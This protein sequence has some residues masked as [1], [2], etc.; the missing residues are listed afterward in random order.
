MSGE[1]NAKKGWAAQ[2]SD[3]VLAVGLVGILMA[4]IIPLP[5]VALDVLLTLN[6]SYALLLL[7]IVLGVSSPLDLSTFPSLLL[8]GTLLRLALNV[9]STRLIL[10]NAYAGEVIQSFGHFVVGGEMVVG[11]V[12]FG[13]LV[14]IQFVVITKGADRISEVTARFTLD[15]MPGKQ[16]SIDA[17]LNAGLI[18]GRQAKQRREE[19]VREAEFYGSMDGASKYIRGDAIAGI[20][21]IFI[22]LL[23]GMVIGFT[24]GMGI[25]EAI[26]TYS[27]LTVGDGL[28]SQIPAVIT[29]TAAGVLVTKSAS[30][31]GLSRELTMEMLA[32]PR[33]IGI[34]SVAISLFV[35]MPGLPW[36]PFFILGGALGGIFLAV[37]SGEPSEEEAEEQEAGD[38]EDEGVDSL[39]IP[40]R[41][42]VEVGYNLIPLMGPGEENTLL[43]RI[44]SLREKLAS[45][46]GFIIPRVRVVD[47]VQLEGNDYVIKL[48]GH[49]VTRGTI[50]PG[51][52]MAM[53][54]G[55]VPD[56]LD[57]RRATEPSFGMEVVWV[58]GAEKERAERLG[59]TVVD[60][61]SVFIT[62]LSQVIKNHAHEIFARQDLQGLLDTV[63][64]H[65]PS[66]V[67]EVVPEMVSTARLQQV[68]ENL[69][70]RGLPINQLPDI[71]EACGRYGE[72]V[73]D[74][75]T[76][77]ELV[78]KNIKRAICETYADDDGVL[79][80]VA[81]DPE[82]EAE[83]RSALEEGDEQLHLQLPPE[84]LNEL[85]DSLSS[86][87]EQAVEVHGSPVL[88]TSARLRRQV[89]EL[90]SRLRIEVPVMAY[91]EVCE[92]TEM[93][94]VELIEAGGEDGAELPDV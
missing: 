20:I 27:I 5:P 15:A 3:L 25:G 78:R 39:V 19:I 54:S 26:T 29:S 34:A 74:P 10:L 24:R 87:L 60:P 93:E 83:L 76:L 9:A 18:D 17:D 79:Q 41:I 75:G 36:Y 62:H 33:A 8:M 58:S 42:A 1:V 56:E 45:E 59:C 51:L 47:N 14:V 31:E 85:L 86:H 40:D 32:N 77:T 82:L 65:S 68:L 89:E 23:G 63:K 91:E 80:A 38:E 66:L 44:R 67:N 50:Y 49:T 72:Q 6:F 73:Q 64:E 2:H 57:G 88:V 35:F 12:V 21:I 84:R 81:F 94:T 92:S 69:L 71:L 55:G 30:D 70:A 43:P 37:R 52:S 48:S 13:I 4:L 28:V 61:G 53:K 16:M 90:V 7:M 46:M 11:L 22:N